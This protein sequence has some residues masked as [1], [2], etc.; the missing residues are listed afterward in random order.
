MASLLLAVIYLTFISLGLPDS[1]LGTA[2][3]VMHVE[4]AAPVA[5]QSLI[6]IIISCCTIVSSLLTAKLVHKLGTGKLTALSVALTAGAILGFSA[7]N[8]FWQLCL[9]AIPYGLGAGAIDSALN[10]YVALNY[11]ARHMSWLH[12]CWGIG[13]SVGPLVMGWALAGPLSWHGGYLAI[14]AMQAI[15]TAALFLSLPLWKSTDGRAEDE[16]A[17][18]RAAVQA[19]PAG[20]SRAMHAGQAECANESNGPKHTQTVAQQA[21]GRAADHVECEWAAAEPECKQAYPAKPGR[22]QAEAAKPEC[23]QANPA[24]PGHK[25][26]VAHPERP[27]TNRELLRL[28]GARAAIG[29]FGTY[30]ALEG[31]IG[32]WIASYLTMARGLDAATA[33]SIVSQFFLGITIGRLVSGFAAQ[34]LTSENQIRLGQALI[35]GGLIGLVALN[36]GVA[37]GACTFVAG[38]GCAPIYPSI[39]ALTPKRFGERASQGLVSL[40]M[41]CAY[42]GSMLFPPVFGL[43]AGA[44]GAALIPL[45]AI[46]LLGSHV[47]LAERAARATGR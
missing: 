4:L 40:Q 7:T 13:A 16:A 15:I 25:Q 24:A 41:A 46:A 44:G 42:A 33:A 21:C 36:G 17:N 8:A 9:I 30:C 38:L 39:V 10:N 11:G 43:V 23:R 45:M 1:L 5:V 27:L 2:W 14:G 47:V 28:P 19:D 22:K 3:P 35:A 6:S 31:S 37:A 32:L 18:E 26:T 12:C 20:T 29:S 34:W